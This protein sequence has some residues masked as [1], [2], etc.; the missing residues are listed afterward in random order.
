VGAAQ[1]LMS[2]VDEAGSRS[3]KYLVAVHGSQ[4]VQIGDHNTWIRTPWTAVTGSS[5]GTIQIPCAP[6]M[7]WLLT[8][9]FSARSDN[10]SQATIGTTAIRGPV[11][12][13]PA[14]RKA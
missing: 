9:V 12:R 8:C 5:A 1:A 7:T 14:P 4:G 6:L 3:G 11:S 2:L 10:G 13:I